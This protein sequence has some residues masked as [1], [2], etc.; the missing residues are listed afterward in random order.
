MHEHFHPRP[1]AMIGA[2]SVSGLEKLILIEMPGG[3]KIFRCGW[4]RPSPEPQQLSVPLMQPGAPKV[5]R[6]EVASKAP[7]ETIHHTP[8]DP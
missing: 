4:F 6:L 2:L 1:W 5:A 8:V 7:P 3:E